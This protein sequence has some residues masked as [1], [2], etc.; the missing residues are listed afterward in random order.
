M[1]R[2]WLLNGDDGSRDTAE[3]VRTLAINVLASAGFQKSYPFQSSRQKAELQEE[4]ALSSYRDALAV[5]LRNV[6]VIIVLP[7]SFF[8]LPFLPKR[9]TKIGMAMTAFKQYMLEEIADEKLS[10]SEGKPGSGSLVSNL[11]RASE[12]QK[13]DNKNSGPRP[14]ILKPLSIPEILGNIFVF[15]FA[16]H[17]TTAISLSYAVL[18]LVAYPEIQDWI[19]EEINQYL[20]SASSEDSRSYEDNFPKLQRC[21]AVLVCHIHPSSPRT[22]PTPT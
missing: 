4:A 10:I 22:F 3:D 12:Q 11:V 18:L 14:Q 19:S 2:S 20:P 1:L 9:W 15:N 7:A 5:V 17:D 8:T 13:Q 21:L 16:G 6:L